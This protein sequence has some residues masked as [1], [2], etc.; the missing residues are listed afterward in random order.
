MKDTTSYFHALDQ[1][2]E[3]ASRI[4]QLVGEQ[5]LVTEQYNTGT[6]DADILKK[7]TRLQDEIAQLD[8]QRDKLLHEAQIIFGKD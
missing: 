1:I 5:R 8:E 4:T 7:D 2:G 3:I 6:G